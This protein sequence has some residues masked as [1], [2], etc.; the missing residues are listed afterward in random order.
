M[1]E[2]KSI[3]SSNHAELGA[4]A[5]FSLL[6]H[7]NSVCVLRWGWGGVYGSKTGEGGVGVGVC[8]GGWVSRPQRLLRN[9]QSL[10]LHVVPI[11]HPEQSATDRLSTFPLELIR[12]WSEPLLLSK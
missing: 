9:E 1:I 12:A 6:K 5:R 7:H 2:M 4:A 3:R 8:V 10:A 11:S